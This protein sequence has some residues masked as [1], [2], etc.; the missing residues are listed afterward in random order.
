MKEELNVCLVNDSFPP[1][2]DGVANAVFN[3]ASIIEKKYGHAI[4]STPAYPGIIDNYDFE[5]MRYPSLNTIG[6]VGYRA[7]MPLDIRYLSE[8]RNKNVDIIHSH[9]PVASNFMARLMR[10]DIK[11]PIV[12][13][14]HTKFDIDIR[15]IVSAKLIQ[16][17]AI[18]ALVNNIQ[19]VDDVWV[20]SHGA[21]ENLRSLGYK[22]DYIVM[23]NGVD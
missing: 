7:G 22:G 19:P 8:F 13:T 14:Y 23:P 18:T 6:L 5:V 15:R 11:K 20:V 3:Y 16:D 9:C 1:A 10:D 12:F 2:I 17:A 4:V 21:G